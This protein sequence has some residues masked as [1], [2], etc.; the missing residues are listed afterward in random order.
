MAD[1]IAGGGGADVLAKAIVA[2]ASE[3]AEKIRQA[4]HAEADRI[5]AEA[6]A[7]AVERHAAENREEMDRMRKEMVTELALA[8]F[9]ARRLLL[10][11]REELIEEIFAELPRALDALRND[12]SYLRLLSQLAR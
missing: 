9:E 3:E 5:I 1:A 11:A 10:N 2:Q 4:A 8:R 6:H 12:P 7:R